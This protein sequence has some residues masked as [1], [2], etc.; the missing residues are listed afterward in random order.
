VRARAIWI[1]VVTLAAVVALAHER[2]RF[3]A[4]VD[5]D[6]ER[7]FAESVERALSLDPAEPKF[8]NFDWQANAQATRLAV[9]LERRG[10]RWWVRENWPLQFGADRIVT[11][12][13][14]VQPVASSSFW[15][16]VLHSNPSVAGADPRAIVFP[17]T[18]DVDLVVHPGK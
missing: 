9:Y 5:Q 12:G 8:L 7:L 10:I 17:I 3:R 11:R 4:A 18:P 2:R 6:Q 16:M 13:S 14:S 1:I 15:A